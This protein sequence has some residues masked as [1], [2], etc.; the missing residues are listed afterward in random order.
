VISPWVK[1]GITNSHYWTVINMVRSIEQILG[2]PAMN[3]NDAAAEPMSEL[4]TNKPDFA[5]YSFEQNQIPLDTLNGQ[6]DSNTASLASTDK[7]TKQT[8]ELSR[9][10]TEWSNKNKKLFTGKN[11]SPDEVNANMLNHSVWYATKGFDKPYPGDKKA[12]T[13]AEV[14]KQP[15]SSAPSPADND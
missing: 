3:Q 5:P 13:P 14:E 9:Q 8:E 4:F 10:W 6:P 7:V 11:A 1:K 15:E 2:L 12:H